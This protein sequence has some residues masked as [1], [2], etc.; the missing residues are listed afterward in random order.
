MMNLRVLLSFVVAITCASGYGDSV[1]IVLDENSFP[2]AF[3]GSRL[4]DALENEGLSGSF[5]EP[6]VVKGDE[7]IRIKLLPSG[8]DSTIHEEGFS[9]T[10]TST[11][12]DIQ[13]IDETGAMYGL[14]ELADLIA[15]HG[16]EKV[17]EKTVNPRF[18]FRAIKFN[19]PWSSYRRHEALQLHHDTVRDM[20]F[21]R[22]YLDMMTE[23]RFNVLTLWS[24]HPFPYMIR[25][26]NFPKAC[27]FDDA[28]LEE[29]R[30][31]WRTLFKEAKIRGIEVYL[32]NWNVF[33]SKGYAEN[34]DPGI[35]L[36]TGKHYVVSNNTPTIERY[37]K[38]C[39]TQVINEYP[40]LTGLGISL[41]EGMNDMGASEREQWILRTFGEGMKEADRK[42]KFIHRVPFTAVA[43]SGGSTDRKTETMTR[44]A[45]ESLDVIQPVWVEIKFNWSH[46]HS[47][48]KLV[49]VH[50][51]SISDAY[52]NPLPENYAITWMIRNE[53]FY[54]L[55]WGEPDFIRE[56]IEQNGQSYVGGYFV[57]SE[58]YIPAK[59]Y[60]HVP[61]HDHINWTYA[62]E[63]QWLF[64]KQW[65]RLLYD[66]ETPDDAFVIDFDNRY[67]KGV[68]SKMV[69]AYK[70]AS[71]MP[72]RFASYIFNTWD[73]TLYAE[74]MLVPTTYKK[75]GYNDKESP[76]LSLEE[77]MDCDVLDPDYLSVR[78]YVKA[79]RESTLDGESITPLE[80]AN[81]L[82]ESGMEA[83]A[84]VDELTSSHP[85]LECEIMD[86]QAWSY[87]SL[88]FA[89]KLR[90]A[91]YLEEYRLS[92]DDE[93]KSESVSRLTSAKIHWE[94]LIGV[95]KPHHQPV[96]GGQVRD[97]EFSWEHFLDQV[98]RDI[99]VAKNYDR[100]K[101][102]V[103]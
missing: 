53:D 39:V 85:T 70:L 4:L 72:L 10:R 59:E 12:I 36:D 82:Q 20:E 71:R 88:Y 23:N 32:V 51:G 65:G 56:H 35:N 96:P 66:P 9:L 11:G 14:L 50:G 26:T 40:N 17:P 80:L 6:S 101:E 81:E 74:G 57:G 37:T 63:R 44:E 99:S 60:T 73:F 98:E 34:Y 100:F 102:R 18:P 27:S 22:G 48:P 77:L 62:W 28:E 42:I 38:E 92:G 41:G 49:Q 43:H 8:V 58:C 78:D 61:G 19:L 94:N 46:A 75:S 47:T 86:V 67:G 97:V 7:D 1:R 52:W 15:I 69:E 89:E 76:F 83:L 68:G 5:V 33:G 91:V 25:P 64:Y 84:L 31:F 45:I 93:K 30:S 79:V 55:R 16:L 21:W 87:Q 29:W 3:G 103:R 24:M 95:T 2:Q 90:A 54:V 13:A